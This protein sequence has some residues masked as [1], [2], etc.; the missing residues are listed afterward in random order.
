MRE[1]VK[2]HFRLSLAG[3][4]CFEDFVFAEIESVYL[5]RGCWA[6]NRD[7]CLGVGHKLL[8]RLDTIIR[9]H[10]L[11]LLQKIATRRS[12]DVNRFVMQA[13]NSFEREGGRG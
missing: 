5:K 4:C 1:G 11:A 6:R 2:K 8:L 13:N 10:D 7:A 3:K 9:G 12:S